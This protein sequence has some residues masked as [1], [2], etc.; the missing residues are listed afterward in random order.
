MI[1]GLDSSFDVP[2]AAQ[3]TQAKQHGVRMWSGYLATKPGVG[4]GHPWKKA[5]FA[6]VKA[7]GMTAIGF[8]SGH[9]DPAACKALAADW[10]VL[11]CLDVESGI[12]SDGPWVKAWLHQSEAGLYGNAPV[13]A[14]R[15]A[16]FFVLA[17]FPGHD[18]SRTWTTDP[19]H[20]R[21]HGPCGWQWEGTHHEFGCGVDRGWYDDWFVAHGNGHGDQYW[22]SLRGAVH[23]GPVPVQNLDGRLELFALDGRGHLQ[24]L[25]QAAPNGGWWSSWVDLG[26]PPPSSAAGTPIAA[27]NLDGRLEVFLRANNGVVYHRWQQGAGGA[28]TASWTSLGGSFE[29]DPVCIQNLDGRLEL[30]ALGSNSH[31]FQLA[32]SAANGTW[33]PSWADLGPPPT[34]GAGGQPVVA[35][36]LDGRL[37][38]LLR[39]G[40]GQLYHRAQQSPGG[41]FAAHWLP[42]AGTWHQDPVVT[43]NKD[44]RLELFAL[45]TNG[46][47][48]D[49]AQTTANG[50]WWTSPADLGPPPPGGAA[51][52]PVAARNADG[53]LE[54]F[55]R[56]ADRKLYHRWQ[57]APGAS[58]TQAWASLGGSLPHDPV[59]A[60]N[61]DGRLEAFALRANHAVVHDWQVAPGQGWA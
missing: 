25:A 44:G 55:V 51:G 43:Q 49:L 17:A 54:V 38:V 18:P 1:A 34:G 39:A 7:A 58:L 33:W 37:E 3:L 53:R 9:D 4:L 47:L 31:L 48:H 24:D 12:R 5:E 61:R 26:P 20:P 11:L 13:F 57:Q 27:R 8:C 36:N 21:P 60:R 2:T 15:Q 50:T 10:G 16:A 52:K 40:D 42:L 22:S 32:Q 6:R 56:G 14:N 46:H 28:L 41:A 35:R 29:H 19:H 45:G 59:V 23:R 30:F